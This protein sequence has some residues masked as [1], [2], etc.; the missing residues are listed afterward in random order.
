MRPKGGW[1]CVCMW[2]GRNTQAQKNLEYIRSMWVRAKLEMGIPSFFP[3]RGD[4]TDGTL[5]FSWWLLLN[6]TIKLKLRRINS[7]R[8]PRHRNAS[9]CGKCCSLE[10]DYPVRPWNRACV[11]TYACPPP[12]QHI[13]ELHWPDWDQTSVRQPNWNWCRMQPR[14]RGLSGSL[15]KGGLHSCNTC[16]SAFCMTR[17][18]HFPSPLRKW[19]KENAFTISA[20]DEPKLQLG[21]KP[22]DVK[23][24]NFIH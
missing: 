20:Q 5:W 3:H 7:K 14:W 15:Q 9:M 17:R 16:T 4:V 24:Q 12:P 11:C 19:H 2:E 21:A 22:Q 10:R 8:T 18:P 13:D 6:L 1:K 23:P